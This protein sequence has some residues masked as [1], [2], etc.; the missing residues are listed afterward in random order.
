M[1]D[2]EHDPNIRGNLGLLPSTHPFCLKP[3]SPQSYELLL[4]RETLAWHDGDGNSLWERFCRDVLMEFPVPPDKDVYRPVAFLYES[5]KTT[6]QCL[7]E[8]NVTL[9]FERRTG[10]HAPSCLDPAR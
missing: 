6:L 9:E 5:V 10:R 4:T 2:D 7:V 1:E 8:S 3:L